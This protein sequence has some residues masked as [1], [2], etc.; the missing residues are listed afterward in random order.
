MKSIVFLFLSL[1]LMVFTSEIEDYDFSYRSYD[2]IM[3]QIRNLDSSYPFNVR[4][5]NDVS[6]EMELPDVLYCGDSK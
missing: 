1:V 2:E 4:V 5:Y 6:E 3:Q